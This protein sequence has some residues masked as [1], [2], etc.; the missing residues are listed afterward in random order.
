MCM[1]VYDAL[2]PKLELPLI[3]HLTWTYCCPLLGS[4][5]ILGDCRRFTSEIHKPLS[6]V[7]LPHTQMQYQ[8]LDSWI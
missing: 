2:F 4:V 1:C 5:G 8:F 3:T 6:S 7:L